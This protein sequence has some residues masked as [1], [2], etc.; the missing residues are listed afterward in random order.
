VRSSYTYNRAVIAALS[1]LITTGVCLAQVTVQAGSVSVTA[2]GTGS[3][4][5][6]MSAASGSSPAGVEWTLTYS[7]TAISGMTLTASSTVTAAGKTLT[8]ASSTGSVKCILEGLNTT[9]IP[10]G[11]IAVAQFTVSTSAPSS[12]SIG[13]TGVVAA[14][15]SAATLSATGTGGTLSVVQGPHLSTLACTPQTLVTP[16]TASC[17][18]GLSAAATS[19]LAL[20]L[21]YTVSQAQVTMPSSASISAGATGT[22]FSVQVAAASAQTSLVVTASLNGASAAFTITLQPPASSSSTAF[23]PIRVRAGGAAYTDPSGNVWS[24]DTGYTGGTVYSTTHAITNSTA[25]PLYQYE[26]YGNVKYQFTVPNGTHT[27]TLKFAELY[28]TK[29]GQRVF[30]VAINGTTVLSNFDIFA[31]AGAEYKAIDESFSVP[32]TAG[33]VTIQFTTVVNN[34][35]IDAIQIQ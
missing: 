30:N 35:K 32:V 18:I 19:T 10:N 24:A 11:V 26:R 20:T 21:G 1:F 22:S 17:T 31:Q 3:V 14:S 29:A 5:I 34:A 16:G 15:P 13:I 12:L 2:G 23:T 25:Q 27:V 7:T 9:A 33:T 8:C 4:N 6:S 28:W